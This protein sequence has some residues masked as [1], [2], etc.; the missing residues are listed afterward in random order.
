MI[1]D[2]KQAKIVR[3][4]QAVTN[5]RLILENDETFQI[6]SMKKNKQ[7][8][9]RI[10]KIRKMSKDPKQKITP[11]IKKACQIAECLI[12]GKG[13]YRSDDKKKKNVIIYTLFR[14]NV[15]L[16]AGDDDVNEPGYLSNYDPIWITGELK[17]KE[18]EDRI[19][20][21][22][23]WNP[24]EE[25]EGKILV[26]TVGSIAE[27]VSLHKNEKGEAVCQDV[28]YLERGYNAWQYMQSKYR[29]YRI[30]SDKR[31]P[32]QYYIIQS[33]LE[34]AD[35]QTGSVPT[36]DHDIDRILEQ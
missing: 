35:K 33:E 22:K 15:E 34:R 10:E 17:D 1:E 19:N 25:N 26:A 2:W 9:K 28:I 16:I 29:V 7:N 20:D 6:A 24:D 13:K 32:I 8:A 23:N 31:K 30:G 5:P 3:A 21:F 4:L 14:G 27:A 11:K 18:R 36:M 12:S